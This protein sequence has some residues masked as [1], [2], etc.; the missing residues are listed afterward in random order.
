MIC[1]G[2]LPY[3]VTSQAARNA[4]RELVLVGR[5]ARNASKELVSNGLVKSQAQKKR[6]PVKAAP[7]YLVRWFR[8]FG[9]DVD[10]V[11]CHLE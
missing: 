4:T 3:T 5:A 6:R 10:L 2:V 8:W 1:Q 7:C 9:S 11:K